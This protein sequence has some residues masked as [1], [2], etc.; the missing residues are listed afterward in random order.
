MSKRRRAV[1][2]IDLDKAVWPWK[3]PKGVSEIDHAAQWLYVPREREPLV[4]EEVDVSRVLGR[5]PREWE[6]GLIREA[7]LTARERERRLVI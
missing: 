5:A 1:E 4:E 6:A 7:R 3:P 2:D